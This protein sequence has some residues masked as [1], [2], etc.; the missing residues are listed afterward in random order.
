MRLASANPGP[1]PPSWDGVVEGRLDV[2]GPMKRVADLSAKLQLTKV[3][4][5]AAPETA[6]QKIAL[7]NNGP[8]VVSLNRQV[9]RIES[10]RLAGPS[11][12]LTLGG[13]AKLA[14]PASV[15]ARVDGNIGLD[16]ARLFSRDIFASGNI[17]IAAA[18]RGPLSKPGLDGRLE[19][20]NA[21]FNYLDAPNG[22]SNGNGVILF[23]GNQAVIQKLTG[24][25]GGGRLEV[26]GM[27]RYGGPQMDFRARVTARRVR[28]RSGDISVQV[29]SSLDLAGTSE[30]SVLSGDV[31]ILEVAMYSHT[32]LGATLSQGAAPVSTPRAKSPLLAGMRLD[33]RIQTAPSVRFITPLSQNL[34]ADADLRVRGTAA[35]PGMLG[36]V[37]VTRGEIMFFGTRYTV[38]QGTVN[39]YDP[40]RISPVLNVSLTTQAKGVNVTLAVS[41]P[42]ENLKLT[43][44]SD[45]PL[46][47]SDIVGLLAAGKLPTTDPVLAASQPPAPQQSFGQMGASAVLGEAV[48]NPVSGRLQRL[49]GITRLKIDPQIIGAE[50]TPQA[51]VTLEQQVTREIFFT[52][53]QDVRQSNP[54]VI[55]IE[56]AI[57]PTWS[58]VATRQANGQFGVD[59]FYKTRFK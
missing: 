25:T 21:N 51:R 9:V 18:V 50:N 27:L 57:D 33:M 34:S 5:T 44:H 8:I 23:S 39:F 20:V 16:I 19:L 46:Q 55:R 45:P 15:D 37:Q 4:V 2:S 6:R 40:G 58:A 24:E 47:F 28:I 11:T 53:I 42:V 56:W 17:R 35:R 41:G 48:A 31:S 36:R 1:Q 22:L 10:A 7:R 29:N 59:F 26:T 13:G 32:D 12:T 52:Y 54:Q 30:S 3:E 43:Y 38:D 49:F 14:Q